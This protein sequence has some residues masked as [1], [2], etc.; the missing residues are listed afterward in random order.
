M[1][2][3]P[4]PTW[5]IETKKPHFRLRASCFLERH[6]FHKVSAS[7]FLYG[8]AR[9]VMLSF[10]SRRARCVLSS[11][12]MLRY[13]LRP[14]RALTTQTPPVETTAVHPITSSKSSVTSTN[15][16]QSIK[17][18]GA[19]K[20]QLS[21]RYP[22]FVRRTKNGNLPVYTDT[23]GNGLLDVV[24]IQ[25]IEGDIHVGHILYP[26]PALDHWPLLL[27]F[28]LLLA[29]DQG[30]HVETQRRFARIAS[31]TRNR[32]EGTGTT[33]EAFLN[34]EQ[35]IYLLSRWAMEDSRS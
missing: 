27:S 11:R 19:P 1:S 31:T 24:H 12:E 3:I 6:V 34:E 5:G 13:P 7:Y 9:S 15:A 33:T 20:P 26:L 16:S 8:V 30:R 18:H 10:L 32:Q 25:R 28:S 17:G 29:T 21:V 22:Y 23:K 35:H 4:R 2:F 14:S